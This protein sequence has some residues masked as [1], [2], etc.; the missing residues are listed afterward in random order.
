M[1]D[2]SSQLGITGA[3]ALDRGNFL[4]HA[5]PSLILSLVCFLLSFV[6]FQVKDRE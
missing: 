6:M 3:A 2:F 5:Y 4:A 1:L